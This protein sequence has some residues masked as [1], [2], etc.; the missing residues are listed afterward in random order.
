[1]KYL[2]HFFTIPMLC[3]F[4]HASIH[5]QSIEIMPFAGHTFS[6]NFGVYRGE[7]R[8]S[9][10]FTYGGNLIFN[11]REL[12]GIDLIYIRQDAEGDVNVVG[13]LDGRDIPLS[14]NYMQARGARYFPLNGGVTA[15]GGLNLRAAGTVSKEEYEQAWRFAIGLVV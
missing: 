7:V 6:E 8:I 14:V 11:I 15:F 10:G 2:F 12:Y 13:F 4:C 3:F 1:M 5:A 9:D